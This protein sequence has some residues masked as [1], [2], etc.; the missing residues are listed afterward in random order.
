MLPDY[1]VL[2]GYEIINSA[3][4]A[5][6]GANVDECGGA[7]GACFDCP[8]MTDW[9]TN[10]E[11]YLGVVQD[12]A[13]WYDPASPESAGIFGVVGLDVTGLHAGAFVSEGNQQDAPSGASRDIMFRIL[14]EAAN[15]C[16]ASYFIGWLRESIEWTGCGDG[17]MGAAACM[18]AC[19]PTFDPTTG[20]P[21]INPMRFMYGLTAIEVEEVER[22]ITDG[23]V[24][25]IY[26]FTLRT[27]NV[28][29][30][31]PPPT[32]RI[33]HVTPALGDNVTLDLPA[34]YEA[35]P[36]PV[37]CLS[38]PQNPAP[39]PPPRPPA[40]LDPRYPANPY[41][42]LR[43]VLTVPAEWISRTLPVV[44]V[45]TVEAGLSAPVRNFLVRFYHNPF[46]ADC[47]LL[48]DLNPCRACTDI[49]IT[50]VPPGGRAV[51]DGRTLTKKVTCRGPDGTS[52]G[53]ATA[54]G[55]AGRMFTYPEF[56]CGASVCIEVFTAVPTSP[57]VA[58]TIALYQRAGAG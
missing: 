12:P 31:R 47:S 51:I 21:D 33:L 5:A 16:A 40:P 57:G 48:P 54:F 25:L 58:V 49:L 15:D 24:Y 17:C 20:E 52:T 23:R 44:P 30:Y 6:Y 8:G 50:Y 38:D 11:G 10:G 42:A 32:E 29:V 9:L 53:E 56:A 18:L 19:C 4:A 41:P 14:V 28:D 36:E 3:R 22:A 43:S 26:E 34:I 35:C 46:D 1:L 13:P 2:N 39:L 45:I 7:I 27:A 37:P 55:P